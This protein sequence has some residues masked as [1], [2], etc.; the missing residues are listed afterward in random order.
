MEKGRGRG[1]AIVVA[2]VLIGGLVETA[3][4]TL[5]IHLDCVVDPMADISR[6]E[7]EVDR[8]FQAAGVRIVWTVGP[9]STR[10]SSAPAT[11]S[12]RHLAV[13]IASIRGRA[14]ASS[15]GSSLDAVLGEA[16]RK[17]GRAHV[18]AD[19]VA[20]A[21]NARTVDGSIVL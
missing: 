15:A 17:W 10:E 6:A 13:I 7:A 14:A 9:V 2:V 19:R 18:F 3:E 4:P 12:T 5:V 16:D 21:V 11:G 20:A 1:A 8:I